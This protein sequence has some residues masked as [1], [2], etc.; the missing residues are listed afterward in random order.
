M[1]NSIAGLSV[2]VTLLCGFLLFE[3]N[4]EVAAMR[5][6]IAEE[7]RKQEELSADAARQAQQK[8][9]LEARLHDSR[10]E[11]L[12]NQMAAQVLRQQ[13]ANATFPKKK[14]RTVSEIFQDQ[15]MREALKAEAEE[16]I[17]KNV[18]A[19]FRDGLADQL[20]L[21]DALKTA[22]QEL[23]TQRMSILWER[24]M[25]PMVTGELDEA[26][27]A[28]E[29]K[30]VKQ[31]IAE[32]TAQLQSL[33]G[34]DGYKAYQAFDQTQ[35]ERETLAKF[36]QNEADAGQELSPDQQSQLMAIMADERSKLRAQN[37]FGDPEKMDF[38][39]WADNF[40]D[41]KISAYGEGLGQANAQILQ[42]AQAILSPE[43]VTRLQQELA[44][45]ALQGMMVVRSTKALMAGDGQ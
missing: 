35:P 12:D 27:M 14:K 3:K 37:D 11:A 20:H 40:S 23:L 18:E 41:D 44:R 13:L 16:G 38:D 29:G 28:Q 24:M 30:A 45:E 43:Q 2:A 42:R 36:S 34:D 17:A 25:V 15:M 6:R 39:N 9:K 19:L 7:D 33:L 5:A 22:L 10:V 1:K 26:G 32:N 4:R 21:N 8:K 31:E